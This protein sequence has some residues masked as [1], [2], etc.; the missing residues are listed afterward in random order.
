VG[1]FSKANKI[2]VNVV[3]KG[4]IGPGWYDIDKTVKAPEG[5]TLSEFISLA[6]KKGIPFREALEN[7]PHLKDTLM[8]NGDRCPVADNGERVLADGDEMYLLA[9]LAGG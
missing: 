3:V 7:S 4:R 5:T 8:L 6:E 1:L 2:R 9:P